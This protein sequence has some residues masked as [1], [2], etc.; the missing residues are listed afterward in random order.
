MH[1]TKKNTNNKNIIDYNIGGIFME[2]NQKIN[3]TVGSC[4]Y[5]NTREKKCSL[6]SIMIA[7]KAN[8]NTENPDESECSSY[9]CK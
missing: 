5:N 8:V 1:K 3:C 9:E 4:K 2:S 6:K 7:P